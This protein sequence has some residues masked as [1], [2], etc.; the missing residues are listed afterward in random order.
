[1]VSLFCLF[2]LLSALV[3]FVGIQFIDINVVSTGPWWY[4][5][6]IVKLLLFLKSP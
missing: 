3:H 5:I 2:L 6:K 4:Y 1:M